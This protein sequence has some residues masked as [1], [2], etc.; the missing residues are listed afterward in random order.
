MGLLTDLRQGLSAHPIELD[1]YLS[2]Q[3]VGLL[4]VGSAQRL[5]KLSTA[6]DGGNI[7]RE[8]AAVEVAAFSAGDVGHCGSRGTCPRRMVGAWGKNFAVR[9]PVRPG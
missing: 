2:G 9:A 4:A 8:A 1:G 7:G 5:A 6:Y 3:P